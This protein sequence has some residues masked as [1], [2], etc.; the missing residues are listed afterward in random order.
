MER[1]EERKEKKYV[2]HNL[3]LH[4]K[5]ILYFFGAIFVG[6]RTIAA[7]FELNASNNVKSNTERDGIFSNENHFMNV[8]DSKQKKT[9]NGIQ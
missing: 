9:P 7:H 2:S 1:I 3:N 5:A 8:F 4:L 6:C